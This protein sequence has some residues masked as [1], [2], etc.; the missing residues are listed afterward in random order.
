VN[1]EE[2]ERLLKK[3]TDGNAALT[4]EERAVLERF[5]RR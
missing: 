5:S 4:A 1:R 2:V 3:V